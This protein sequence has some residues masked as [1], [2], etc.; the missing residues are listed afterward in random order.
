METLWQSLKGTLKWPHWIFCNEHEQIKNHDRMK[1]VAGCDKAVEMYY[2]SIQNHNCVKRLLNIRFYRL[3]C[4]LLVL[5]IHLNCL[6]VSSVLEMPLVEMPAFTKWHLLAKLLV[7][8]VP[9]KVVSCWN[10]FL[11]ANYITT[12]SRITMSRSFNQFC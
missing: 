1:G 12:T 3:F 5:F 8:K 4:S 7:L 9:K 10:N 11:S 6:Q 2:P